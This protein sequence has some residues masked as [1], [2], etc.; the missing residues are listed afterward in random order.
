MARLCETP[1]GREACT[2]VVIGV[3]SPVGI[4]VELI[5]IAVGIRSVVEIVIV[6]EIYQNS[7]L[8]YKSSIY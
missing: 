8:I 2:V 6:L 1:S 3:V 7:S 5:I 4:E